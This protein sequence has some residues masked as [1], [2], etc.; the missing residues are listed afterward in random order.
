MCST[1]PPHFSCAG[2]RGGG[3]GAQGRAG[4]AAGAAQR[5]GAGGAGVLRLHGCRHWP[6]FE[7]TPL[8]FNLNPPV[9]SCMRAHAPPSFVIDPPPPPPPLPRP[10]ERRRSSWSSTWRP[11]RRARRSWR[12]CARRARSST[13]TSSAGEPSRWRRWGLAGQWAGGRASKAP[14]SGVLHGAPA[15]C[16]ALLTPAARAAPPLFFCR[17]QAGGR[18][19]GAGG[20][21]GRPARV[22]RAGRRPPGLQLPRAGWV[23][24]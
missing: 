20:A 19:G 15:E 4:G 3:S 21:P 1:A 2:A 16:G 14:P 10:P 24:G 18:G 22:H 5:D 7:R 9:P 11:A 6:A 12:G 13:P 17:P 8:T 23:G